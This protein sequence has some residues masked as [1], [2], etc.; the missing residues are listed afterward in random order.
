MIS[1]EKLPAVLRV[2]THTAGHL[3]V[4]ADGPIHTFRFT[5]GS[6]TLVLAVKRPQV[7]AERLTRA[8]VI[9]SNCD[10]SAGLAKEL[11]LTCPAEPTRF[12]FCDMGGRRLDVYAPAL[13]KAVGEEFISCFGGQTIAV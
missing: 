12:E 11:G 5:H 2:V 6:A 7:G 3:E 8:V 13:E 1:I 10:T 9:L 4:L